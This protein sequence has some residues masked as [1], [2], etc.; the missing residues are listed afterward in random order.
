M[1]YFKKLYESQTKPKHNYPKPRPAQNVDKGYNFEPK[2]K[3]ILDKLP[4]EKQKIK[5][6]KLVQQK[7]REDKRREALKKKTKPVDKAKLTK[8]QKEQKRRKTVQK[9]SGKN[10]K[11]PKTG[12]QFDRPFG[13]LRGKR[14][15][16]IKNRLFNI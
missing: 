11:I 12:G 1:S 9:Y 8:E 4:E 7:K 13:T 14:R 3:N 5:E 2:T 10:T 6:Q 15:A 16:R